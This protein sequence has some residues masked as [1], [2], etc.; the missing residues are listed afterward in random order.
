M[1]PTIEIGAD[2][3]RVLSG[4]AAGRPVDPGLAEAALEWI[5]E[6]VGLHDERPV[7]VA[8]LWRAVLAAAVGEHCDSVVLVHPDDWP[9]HRIARVVAAANAVADEV[10]ALPRHRWVRNGDA[11]FDGAE[12]D[13]A[14]ADGARADVEI[15]APRTRRRVA[16]GALLA[17]T[18]LAGA[19]L[20][21]ALSLPATPS[22]PTADARAVVEG[23]LAVEV[24]RGWT[25]A[26]VTG[27]PGSRRLQAGPPG[28]PDTAVHITQSYAPESTLQ[29]AADALSR[30][31]AEQPSGVFV[32][33]HADGV[34]VGRPAL[35]YREI[36]PGRVVDWS[37][38]LIGSTLV[39][40]GCQS[41]PPGTGRARETCERVLASAHE[42]GTDPRP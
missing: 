9:R 22:R 7:A 37:V 42:S 17:A 10:V 40:V 12:A 18:V 23:R 39:G 38:V 33:F 24:P 28:D 2:G 41:A 6:P 15:S 19:A 8:G 26:R 4:R 14:Q 16:V 20:I 5:D 11:E 25:V 34:V 35:T 31:I 32:D 36:R 13:G 29:Q 21:A 27:G 1:T 30:R 3:V